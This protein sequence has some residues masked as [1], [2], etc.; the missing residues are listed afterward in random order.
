MM[1]LYSSG[2]RCYRVS[3]SDCRCC[4]ARV[5]KKISS[6]FIYVAAGWFDRLSDAA[7]GGF[8]WLGGGELS[9]A[10]EQ[11]EDPDTEKGA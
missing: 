11:G 3:I 1:F 7:Q 9:E 5:C 8:E 4:G 2:Y 6:W 10:D